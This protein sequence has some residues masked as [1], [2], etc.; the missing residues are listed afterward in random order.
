MTKRLMCS[1][2]P[3]GGVLSSELFPPRSLLLVVTLG[4]LI[5]EQHFLSMVIYPRG[6]GGQHALLGKTRR[7]RTAFTSQQLLELEKQFRQNK[8]LSR[9]KRFE[10]ATSLM[11]T[12]TQVKIWFQ[13]RR[14][15]WKRSKKAQ[16]E[17]KSR[18]EGR[19][20]KRSASKPGT[21]SGGGAGGGGSSA[22]S[23]SSEAPAP[24][25]APPR[26]K[27]AARQQLSVSTASST[28]GTPAPAPGQDGVVGAAEDGRRD[29]G[30]DRVSLAV[31]LSGDDPHG[32]HVLGLGLAPIAMSSEADSV[33]SSP[34]SERA[35]AAGHRAAS[36]ERTAPAPAPAPVT[37]SPPH[38]FPRVPRRFPPPHAFHDEPLYRPYVV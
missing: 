35:A 20:E 16:Q 19:D 17:A 8:Y 12:E 29:S 30:A 13:N 38:G 18:D 26:D 25:S 27:Q 5:A 28:G 24:A 3:R 22:A 32:A 10:V 34:G 21:G 7:P 37:A 6:C 23:S 4:I 14:M 36:P 2:R 11:L 31:S 1:T 33:S 9:P 15:K